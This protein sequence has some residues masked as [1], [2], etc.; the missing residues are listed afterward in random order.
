[1]G[2]VEHFHENVH[3]AKDV[4]KL[5]VR[6]LVTSVMSKED[7][8]YVNHS[9]VLYLDKYLIFIYTYVTDIIR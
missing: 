7:I 6:I 8:T 5:I 3:M 9:I 1:M 4:E 2:L